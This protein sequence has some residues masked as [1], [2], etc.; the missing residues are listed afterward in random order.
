MPY[1]IAIVD[2]HILIAKAIA[3]IINDESSYKVLYE[4]PNGKMLQ[5]KF[6]QKKKHSRCGIVGYIHAGNGWI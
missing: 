1:N 4:V 6:E 2:D 5:E 3:S